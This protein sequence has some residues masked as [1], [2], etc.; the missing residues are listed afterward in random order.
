MEKTVETTTPAAEQQTQ[1]KQTEAE[2]KQV[3]T[4]NK[5]TEAEGKPIE[6]TFTQKEVD[7][8]VKQRL[9]RMEKKKPTVEEDVEGLKKELETWKQEAALKDYAFAKP[10]FKDFIKYKVSQM[11]TDEKDFGTCLAEYMGADGKEF[12]QPAKP[13]IQPTPRPDNQGGAVL[14]ESQKYVLE[15]YGKKI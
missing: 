2:V 10:E 6:K 12:L 15:K 9:A 5:Q 1:V 13:D 4:S 3:E 14:T 8:I 7:E 11:V